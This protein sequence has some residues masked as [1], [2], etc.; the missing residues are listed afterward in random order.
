MRN[1]DCISDLCPTNDGE[2]L[3]SQSC[4]VGV[5]GSCP[6]EYECVAAGSSGV[7]WPAGGGGGCCSLGGQRTGWAQLV[8]FAAVVLLVSTRRRRPH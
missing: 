5:T 1:Q 4:T 8:L 7:C 6:M 2:S 3:C